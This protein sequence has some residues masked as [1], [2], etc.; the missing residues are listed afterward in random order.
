MTDSV[1]IEEVAKSARGSSSGVNWKQGLLLFVILLFVFSD[2]FTNN[3]VSYIPGTV[4]GREIT[5]KGKIM[6]CAMAVILYALV[7]YLCDKGVL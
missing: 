2:I 7:M 1:S 3:I 5:E 4:E 6:L